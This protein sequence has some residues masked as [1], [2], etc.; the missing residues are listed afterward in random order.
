MSMAE[1]TTSPAF[2]DQ[3][4]RPYGD[5]R[6]GKVP[7]AM[8]PTPH[9][10]VGNGRTRESIIEDLLRIIEPS[11]ALTPPPLREGLRETPERVMKAWDHWT[12]GYHIDPEELLKTFEDGAKNYDEIILVRDIPVYSHCEHHLA[13]FFGV[14]HVGYIPCGKIVGLSKLPRVVDAFARRLQVQE[15]LTTQVADTIN[16]VLKPKAVGVVIECRHM[17]MESRGVKQ[18]GTSTRTSALR[19]AFKDKPEARAE[20]FAL[21]GR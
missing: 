5:P 4:G 10:Y 6:W 16:R 3:W 21:I 7:G 13:P 9:A 11:S 12:G 17:C 18:A 20:F 15:R 19:G 14:A 2:A 1:G 8:E